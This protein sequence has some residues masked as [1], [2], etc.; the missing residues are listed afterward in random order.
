VIDA[1]TLEA[2]RRAGCV[3]ISYGAES[4]H[5]DLL[6]AIDKDQSFEQIER[7]V[8]LTHEAGITPMAHFIVGLPGQSERR[9]LEQME[10]IER[11]IEDYN[12]YPGD[13][14]PMMVFPGTPLFESL[15]QWRAH[16]WIDTVSPGF[17]FPNVPIYTDLIPPPRALEL[18]DVLN[19]RCRRLLAAK[20]NIYN[21]T[22]RPRRA[23]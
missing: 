13:F 20:S 21:V 18:S 12:F 9:L 7:G 2:M 1:P 4:L 14:Y 10:T 5:D 16:N 11:W 3:L 17:I 22:V 19:E 6:A 23:E 8:R 15:P